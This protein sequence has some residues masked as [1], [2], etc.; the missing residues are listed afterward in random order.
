MYSSSQANIHPQD[1]IV[2]GFV[3]SQDTLDHL[4]PI[5]RAVGIELIRRGRWILLPNRGCGY[6]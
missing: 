3:L 4:D 6:E 5:K 1:G 2:D